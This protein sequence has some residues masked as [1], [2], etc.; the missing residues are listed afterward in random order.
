MELVLARCQELNGLGDLVQTD[1]AGRML[2]G[3]N[4]T[5]IQEAWF[6]RD[7]FFCFV[8]NQQASMYDP[9]NDKH[10]EHEIEDDHH[11]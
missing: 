3:T 9:C 5:S 6:Q 11:E 10:E 2:G 1:R 8:P 7:S 4:E